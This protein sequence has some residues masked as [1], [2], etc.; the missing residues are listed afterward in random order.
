MLTFVMGLGEVRQLEVYQACEEW[1]AA[2]DRKLKDW[3][4]QLVKAYLTNRKLK[5]LSPEAKKETLG[6]VQMFSPEMPL[7]PTIL[8][9]RP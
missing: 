7:G 3:E 6:N 2:L 8:G 9:P 1:E 5:E 4:R